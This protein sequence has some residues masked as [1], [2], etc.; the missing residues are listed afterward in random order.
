MPA[1]FLQ[2]QEKPN[3]GSPPAEAMHDRSHLRGHEAC[4]TGSQR[5]GI[6]PA[7]GGIAWPNLQV[8]G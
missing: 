7:P 3:G 5:L 4:C 2:K 1:D 8:I 6:G